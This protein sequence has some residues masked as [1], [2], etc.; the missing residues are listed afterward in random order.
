MIIGCDPGDCN[1]ETCICILNNTQDAD[2]N[3]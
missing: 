2:T 1:K 3:S